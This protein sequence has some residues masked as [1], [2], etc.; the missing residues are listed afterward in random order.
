MVV[1]VV[2]VVVVLVTKEKVEARRSGG[3][4]EYVDLCVPWVID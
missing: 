3:D 2:V 4:V 1:D